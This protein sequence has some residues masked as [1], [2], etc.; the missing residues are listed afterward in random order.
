[1]QPHQARGL[2]TSP[3]DFHSVKEAV[4]WKIVKLLFVKSV[5]NVADMNTKCLGRGPFTQVRD[6]VMGKCE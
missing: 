4:I 3:L 1:M 2:V 5:L 6:K